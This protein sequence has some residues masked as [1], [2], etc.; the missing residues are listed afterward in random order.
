[1]AATGENLMTVD[2]RHLIVRS[3]WSAGTRVSGS[4][5]ANMLDCFFARP[6]TAATSAVGALTVPCQPAV[7]KTSVRH[8]QHAARSSG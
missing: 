7:L 6:R 2:T 4:I 5:T 3:G 8:S 1:V